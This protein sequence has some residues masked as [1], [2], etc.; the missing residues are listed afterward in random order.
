MLKKVTSHVTFIALCMTLSVGANAMADAPKRVD[1]SAGELS[2]ALLKL[3]KDYGAELVYRPEQVRGLKTRGV[4]GQFTTEQAVAQLLE[5]TSLELRTDRS[6]AM[7]IAPPVSESAQAADSALQASGAPLQDA[8]DGSKEGKKSSSSDFRV[9][10]VG[11]GAISRPPEV[12]SGASRAS[13]NSKD[14]QLEEVVVTAQKREERLIDVPQSVSVLSADE[15][16]T[17]G[18]T[19]FRD[20]ADTVPGLDFKTSGAGNTQVSL[21]GVTTGT[22][23]SS[24]VGIYVDE[25]PVGSSTPFAFG[26]R[27]AP[28]VGLFDLD[29]IEVLRGPQGTLY[30]A[31]SMGGVLKYVTKQPDETT[32]GVDVRSGLSDTHDGG[33]N[34][35]SSLAVNAPLV[36]DKAAIRASVFESHDGGYID[37][38]ETGTKNVNRSDVYGGRGSLLISPIDTLTI[39]ISGFVQNITRE[40]E[41][42]AD[43]TLAG[44]PMAGDLAQLRGFNELFNSRLRVVSGTVTYDMEV[45]RLTSVSSYQ[46]VETEQLQ[47]LTSDFVPLLKELFGRSYGAVADQVDLTTNKF[48]QEV[49]LASKETGPLEWLLGTFYTR[50]AS[51]DCEH[52]VLKGLAGQFAPNDILTFALPTSF[53]EYAAFGDL[54]WHLTHKL[55]VTGGMR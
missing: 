47:D 15:L 39:N 30:G 8:S 50:E 49:R 35:N 11:Q 52:F 5:G 31:S 46:T 32:L 16:V 38:V 10:Q 3:S 21:R 18:A 20:F 36:T 45:A 9:A 19:Q 55:D 26:A 28:D 29:R 37:N 22:D 12:G 14:T 2:V 53:K 42:T 41:G 48:T 33:I 24:T 4:H 34:Y 25:V 6:G 43:Y 17:L 23:S 44:V 1:I 54:T 40:G 51:C 7:L 27:F 13:E